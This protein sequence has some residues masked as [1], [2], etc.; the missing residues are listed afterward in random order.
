VK[1]V[2]ELLPENS[3]RLPTREILVVRMLNK[4]ALLDRMKHNGCGREHDQDEYEALQ[5]QLIGYIIVDMSKFPLI[6]YAYVS[7]SDVA[8]KTELQYAEARQLIERKPWA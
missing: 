4:K 6:T 2:S 1:V 3:I 7:K 8:G 5:A